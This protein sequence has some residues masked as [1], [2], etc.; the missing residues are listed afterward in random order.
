MSCKVLL[1]LMLHTKWGKVLCNILATQG[2][3]ILLLIP[4]CTVHWRGQQS[5][6]PLG[7]DFPSLVT[8]YL[9][10]RWNN[11]AR[12][13]CVWPLRELMEPWRSELDMRNRL[14]CP[15]TQQ[16]IMFWYWCLFDKKTC[17]I[18]KLQGEAPL[19]FE[20]KL[21]VFRH[22]VFTMLILF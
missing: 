16:P 11:N 2:C 7:L 17:Q 5:S 12:K 20:N 8:T 6:S 18:W 9:L 4:S 15:S 10:H 14:Q 13:I 1:Y 21:S 3:K 19:D 22:L